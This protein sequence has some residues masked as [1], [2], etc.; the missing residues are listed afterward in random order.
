[1]LSNKDIHEELDYIETVR[2]GSKDADVQAN[3][4]ALSLIIKLLH[5]IRTNIVTVMKHEGVELVAPKGLNESKEN[6]D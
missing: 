1:M 6:E 2:Q 5:N 3:L 4:K